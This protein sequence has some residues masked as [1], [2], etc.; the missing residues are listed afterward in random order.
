MSA[1]SFPSF[2]PSFSSFPD[3][4]TGPSTNASEP[5]KTRDF[6]RENNKKK[7]RH[8]KSDTR[9]EK[10]KRTKNTSN[11]KGYTF[12]DDERLKANEDS[13]SQ[14]KEETSRLF[15]SDGKGDRYNVEYGGLHAGE[16]PKYH[17]VD[18]KL[19][20]AFHLDV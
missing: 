11:S 2:P 14:V 19:V 15:F 18:R 12:D 10:R 17:I 4:D 1:P 7:K 9:G 8:D 13:K 16:V 5:L 20:C 6:L 3:L